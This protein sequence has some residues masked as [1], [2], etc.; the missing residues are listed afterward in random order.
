M[1]LGHPHSNSSAIAAAFLKS[2][3]NKIT[4]QKRTFQRRR[5]ADI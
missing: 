1:I 4:P 5:E 3:G 2:L